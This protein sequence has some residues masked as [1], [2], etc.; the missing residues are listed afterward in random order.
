[1]TVTSTE[2]AALVIKR[3]WPQLSMVIVQNKYGVWFNSGTSLAQVSVAGAAID[4]HVTILML[5][6]RHTFAS[7]SGWPTL[8][9]QQ[10]APQ[11]T[12]AFP[13]LQHFEFSSYASTIKGDLAALSL[14]TVAQITKCHWSSLT[15][16]SLSRCGL[17]SEGLSILIHG[18]WPMLQCLDVSHNHIDAEGMALLAK[19]NWPMLTRLVL[20]SNRSMNA[21]G[22]AHLSA[23]NWPLE[24]LELC[25]LPV[26]AATAAALAK[27][28]LPKL[29]S[30]SLRCAG[31]TAAAISG[32]V[33]ADWPHLSY[34]DLGNS[35]LDAAAVQRLSKMQ[36]PVLKVLNLSCTDI[37]DKG[38]HWLSLGHW[39]LLEQ[40]DLSYNNL[41]ARGLEH[42]VCGVWRN[43]QYL[44]L[45]M[46]LIGDDGAQHLIKGDWP[47]LRG[48]TIA[49]SMLTTP[50]SAAILGLDPDR[51]HLLNCESVFASVSRSTV[52]LWPNLSEVTFWTSYCDNFRSQRC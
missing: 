19:G 35:I 29:N 5:R 34:L 31:L 50:H 8:A 41:C 40:L 32:L 38:A 3:A 23:A 48:L 12:A 46:S 18:D 39:P 42:I 1:M 27:L 52:G 30:V 15:S 24:K 17:D 49:Y 14:A 13:E 22:I 28:Q 45:Q 10:L 7:E 21:V 2:D 16:L 11:I 44:R 9:A 33:E 6:P 47:L 51:V 36:L 20:S 25:H 4:S 43:L 26:T 37:T